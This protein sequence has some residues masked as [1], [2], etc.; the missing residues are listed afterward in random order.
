MTGTQ[1]FGLYW[2]ETQNDKEQEREKQRREGRVTD[3]KTSDKK[4]INAGYPEFDI[5]KSTV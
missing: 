1:T 2:R 3:T 4:K 5:F